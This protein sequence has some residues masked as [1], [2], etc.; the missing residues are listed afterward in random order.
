MNGTDV[1]AFWGELDAWADQELSPRVT[2]LLDRA[3]RRVVAD[4]RKV[5]FLDAGGLRLLVRIRQQVAAGQ[6]T[7]WLVPGSARNWRV[8]RITRLDRTFTIPV[9]APH[10]SGRSGAGRGSR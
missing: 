3:G 5:T 7:L 6:G 2:A 10:T 4:L 9:G 8:L 1:L